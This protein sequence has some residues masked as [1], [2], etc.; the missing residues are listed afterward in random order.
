MEYNYFEYFRKD[1]VKCANLIDIKNNE[2]KY[3]KRVERLSYL[4]SLGI[5]K[6]EETRQYLLSLLYDEE[7]RIQSE[8]SIMCQEFLSSMAKSGQL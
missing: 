8:I 3:C 2:K 7:T 5:L 6:D 4:F 1:L